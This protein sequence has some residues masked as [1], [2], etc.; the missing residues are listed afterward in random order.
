MIANINRD[1][2]LKNGFSRLQSG[3]P[4]QMRHKKCLSIVVEDPFTVH[5]A[6]SEPLLK[7]DKCSLAYT[8]AV[9]MYV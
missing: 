1:S 4:F 6:N 5:G 7:S 8:L 9:L 3:R 2:K